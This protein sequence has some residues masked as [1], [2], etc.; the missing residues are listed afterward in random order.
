LYI[1]NILWVTKKPPKILIAAK[2]IAKKPNI[3]E[4]SKTFF[5]FPDKPAIIAPTIITEEIAFVTDIN[6]VCKDGVTLHTT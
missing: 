1:C 4:V 3:F 6:G 5:E 2:N